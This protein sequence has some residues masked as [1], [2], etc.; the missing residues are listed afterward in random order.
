MN[1]NPSHMPGNDPGIS[2]TVAVNEI[3]PDARKK[4]LLLGSI[5]ASGRNA[6][7]QW[8][9]QP[10]SSI[11]YLIFV[12]SSMAC[13]LCQIKP[14]MIGIISDFGYKRHICNLQYDMTWHISG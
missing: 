11:P 10:G 9:L 14:E 8:I 4:T 2:P 3:P 13:K 7:L 6:M 5:D 1:E 12:I